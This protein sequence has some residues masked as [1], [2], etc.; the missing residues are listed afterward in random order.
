V[1]SFQNLLVPL[2]W[3]YEPQSHNDPQI[4][5]VHNDWDK[6]IA[7]IKSAVNITLGTGGPSLSSLT[8]IGIWLEETI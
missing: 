7:L 4:R 8:S 2:V 5:I 1:G 6:P 3:L